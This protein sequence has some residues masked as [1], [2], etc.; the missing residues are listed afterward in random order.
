MTEIIPVKHMSKCSFLFPVDFLIA[1][2]SFFSSLSG[3]VIFVFPSVSLLLIALPSIQTIVLVLLF[4]LLL[5]LGLHGAPS[6]HVLPIFP[7]LLVHF[8]RE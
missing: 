8:F 5:D 4:S 2:S 7:S 6:C 3:E 1:V